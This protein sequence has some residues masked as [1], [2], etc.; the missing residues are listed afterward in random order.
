MA[1]VKV[2]G[3][4]IATIRLST[5]KEVA[6]LLNTVKYTI[7]KQ[8]IDTEI[9]CN[10]RTQQSKTL[11]HSGSKAKKLRFSVEHPDFSTI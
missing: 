8:Y 4:E 11:T 1:S 10:L 6:Y 5:T 3:F 9:W 2:R 7:T